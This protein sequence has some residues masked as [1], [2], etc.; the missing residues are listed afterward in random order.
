MLAQE[1]ARLAA[2]GGSEGEVFQAVLARLMQATEAL[3]GAVWLVTRRNG[4]ELSWK[5]G[6]SMN[7]EEAAGEEGSAQRPQVMR[8]AAEV[9][10][11][12]QPLV[13]MPAPAGQEP[14]TPGVLVNQG[15]HAIVGVPLRSGDDALGTVQLWFPRQSDPKKLADLALK[16]QAL[17]A[18]LGPRL[19]SRQMRDLGLQSRRQQQ[20]L[21]MAMDVTGQ[22]DP[23]HVARLATAHAR[24]LLAV[25]R[26]SLLIQEGDRWRLLGVSGQAQVD[27]RSEAVTQMT[28][29]AAREARETPWVMVHDETRE[30]PADYFQGTPMRSLALVPLRE[31]GEGWQVGLMLAESTDAAA[32]GPA[33]APSDPRAP[34]LALAQW[35]AD[36]TARALAAALTHDSLPLASTLTRLGRWQTKAQASRQRRWLSRI[37]LAALILAIGALWPLKVKVEG[38]CT[39][40]PRQRALVTPE[41]AGR[42]EEVLVREGQR[43]KKDQVIARLDTQRLR[44]ELEV[45]QQARRRLEAEAERQRG[46]GKEALARIA[47]LEAQAT[48]EQEKRLSLEI[49]LAELRAPMDGVVMTREVH[50]R[51]GT[52]LEAGEVLAEIASVEGWDLRLEIAEADMADLKEALETRAPRSVHYLLYTQSQQ[53]LTARLESEAQISPALHAGKS[54][55]VFSIYL[56]QVE[57][58]EKLRPHMRPGLTGRAK[59]ELDTQAGGRVLMRHFIRW[60]RM[61]WWL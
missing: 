20:L 25:N 57:L 10:L 50:L 44:T 4:P 61:R 15:P 14:V 52:F 6:A 13:L 58:P 8:A 39:L 3:G 19:R 41:A 59:I 55:G 34:A 28:E 1:L 43:V 42:V 27:A 38:D 51:T 49:R 16:L 54:G 47:T 48:A 40:L 36:L 56:P 23:A 45:T 7:L 37:G 9:V 24:E 29:L 22:L 21:Q 2:S 11:A 26:V 32:F 35:L 30:A 33:G 17:M 31:G 18:D 12:A 53:E 46:Q 5:C 60:L